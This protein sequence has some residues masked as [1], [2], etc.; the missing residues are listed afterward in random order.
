MGQLD[1]IIPVL[2]EE[3]NVAQLVKRLHSALTR[4]NLRHTLIFVDDHSQDGTVPALKRLSKTYPIVI[5]SKAGRRGKAYSIIEGAALAKSEYVAMIDGDLQYPPEAL[6]QMY[7]QAIANGHSVVVANRHYA[8]VSWLRRFISHSQRLVFSRFLLGFNC[9]V[10]SGLKVFRRDLAYHLSGLQLDA[11]ALD[12]PL[13]HAAVGLGGTIGTIDI[14]FASRVQGKS[15]VNLVK[16]SWQIGTQAV[17]LRFSPARIYHLPPASPGSPVGAGI[18]HRKQ[19]FITHSQLPQDQSAIST[20]VG[21]QK[22]ALFSVLAIFAVS[23]ALSLHTALVAFIGILSVLYFADTVFNLFLVLKS[24]SFP[25]ELNYT[26]AQIQDLADSKLPTYSILC[27]L[28]REAKVLPAFVQS[29]SQLDWPKEKLDVMLLL[30]ENDTETISA[31]KNLHLPSYF[32]IVVVPHSQPKTKPKACNYGLAFVRGEYVVIYDAEDKPDPLQLKKAYL[33]FQNSPSQVV[34]LQAKLN[35]YNPSHN[36]LTRL[37]TAEYSLWF[38]IT[39]PGLQ[40]INTSIPLG[41][42]SNHFRTAVL[43]ELHGWDAFNVTEDCD[44][45]ARL[46][47][48]GYKTAIIDS[49]TLEEANSNVGNWLR[50]R[51][52]WI[53]GYIQTYLVHNRHPRQFF[54]QHGIHA[55]IF[56]LVVGGKI[57]FMVINP[58]LWATTISYFALYKYVGPAIESLYPPLIFYMAAFSLIFGNFLFMYYY[59]LGSAKRGH[60]EIVKYVYLIPFYWLLVSIASL[61]AWYQ[62]IVNPHYWEKT[63]HGLHLASKS[64]FSLPKIQLPQVALPR[65]PSFP[66]SLA[67]GGVLVFSAAAI[68]LSNLL[69]NVYLPRHISVEQLGVVGL[70]SSLAYFVQVPLGALSQSVTHQSANFFGKFQVPAK[71]FWSFVRGRVFVFSAAFALL[72]IVALPLLAQ[73]FR[74]NSP[75][76]LLMFT[77]VLVLAA[78]SAVDGGFLRGSLRFAVIAIMGISDA[79]SKFALVALFVHLHRLDLLYL[80]FPLSSLFSLGLG[81]L[82]ASRYSQNAVAQPAVFPFKFFT[83][84]LF[85]GISSISF[86]ALDVILAKIFLSPVQA[87]QYTLLSL[88]GK[89]VYFAGSLFSQFI[90]PVISFKDGRGHNTRQPFLKL[91]LA[92]GSACFIGFLA[93]GAFGKVV[94][95]FI[96]GSRALPL[97]PY[98][99]WYA[100]AMVLLS[101]SSAVVNYHQAKKQYSLSLVSVFFSLFMP[102]GMFLY[103]QDI[104]SLVAVF[105]AVAAG[106]L[107]SVL[108]FHFYPPSKPLIYNWPLHDL[109]EV[110]SPKAPRPSAAKLR[111]LIFNWRDTRHVW[112]GGAEVYIHEL[113]KR[114]VASGNEVAIFCGSDGYQSRNDEIDGVKIIRRGGTYLVYVWAFLY[115]IFRFRGRYDFVI[116]CENGIPFF[117]PL[118]VRV[119]K[120][121]LIHHVHQ[122]VFRE[123]LGFPL[124]QIGVFLE[125]KLM[126]FVYRNQHIIT[127]SDSSKKDILGLGFSSP[128]RIS[129][130][131]PGIDLGKFAMP[132]PKTG[133]PSFVYLGRIRPYKNI[134]IAIKAFARVAQDY[135][136]AKL[137][138]AGAGENLPSLI[139]LASS[140]GLRRQVHFLGKVSEITKVRLLTRS[141]A[142]LQPSSFEGWGITVIEANA[143]GTPVIASDV[144]GLRDSVL[145]SRTGILV[146]QKNVLALSAAMA[147]IIQIPDY[148]H[149]LSSSAISWAKTFDWEINSRNFYDIIQSLLATASPKFPFL[150][151][152][153]AASAN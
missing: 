151:Q 83:T 152:P 39:L 11:W 17:K 73:V 31:A 119:P 117:T 137:Y 1:V 27:P 144:I 59:M 12:M 47:K 29:I 42:T 87:G 112:A 49:V 70:L 13:L 3:G 2:N 36:L 147:S 94:L 88:A 110:F 63:H 8:G 99:P 71:S 9:D 130:I 121:L 96:F 4:A 78:L 102:I 148:R 80:S 90:L 69:Y 111:I 89:M 21:W 108:F 51:S 98:L 75:L 131:N 64:K 134:D 7:Q 55:L 120:V 92:S 25:P 33:A 109:L 114:W 153:A 138:I 139:K 97:V 91:L 146:P 118:F 65:L 61:K 106:Q 136:K 20:L 100:G 34:C 122:N 38:D 28:Y 127:V 57:A 23:L 132:L 43:K 107:V 30:E 125:T 60:W 133:Y 95:P 143:C 32:R 16:T 77:P 37:F 142:M 5:H 35:Y 103:H 53:K 85:T 79:V 126:P 82:V 116:D 86:L 104:A 44:L 24:L 113:A 93:I 26:D 19:K 10:Q 68:N 145:D 40:S 141:W 135:P 101:L 41:G 105:V 74:L 14:E 129:I 58:I 15:K 48:H 72:W 50:Q 62:L 46:F 149:R 115:Y 54:K 150:P 124:S 76:P 6:P 56:Q 66:K 123:H 67:G 18:I 52:R 22:V 81:W 140:L 128:G 45:G 84:S